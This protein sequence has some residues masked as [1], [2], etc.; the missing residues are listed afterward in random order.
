[1]RKPGR[2]DGMLSTLTQLPHKVHDE[3]AF[4]EHI[5][6]DYTRLMFSTAKRI[7]NSSDIAEDVVQDS[8][9]RLMKHTKK[10]MSLSQQRLVG[11]LVIT[12]KNTALGYLNAEKIRE[13][14][15]SEIV[16]E[17][18]MQAFPSSEMVLIEKEDVTR[19]YEIWNSLPEV[20]RLILES[21]YDLD[22]ADS[23]IAKEIGCKTGSVR[24][25]LTRARRKALEAFK[26]RK[27]EQN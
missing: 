8:L 26:E 7:V 11:Y 19:F 16:T 20:D 24:M 1:M 5:V 12:V 10:L 15:E 18:E 2:G 3:R 17:A 22:K 6:R 13:K 14:Y 4:M 21:K 9:E 25:K 23:E 27:N